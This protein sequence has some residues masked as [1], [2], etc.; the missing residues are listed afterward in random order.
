MVQLYTVTLFHLAPTYT[1]S[2]TC[3]LTHTHTHTHTHTRHTLPL[4]NS[5]HR[6]TLAAGD[7]IGTPLRTLASSL[8]DAAATTA[9]IFFGEVL[10]LDGFLAS[11]PPPLTTGLASPADGFGF[12]ATGGGFLA[13]SELDLGL[14]G[15]STSSHSPLSP[16]SLP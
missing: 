9:G 11:P 1:H 16:L 10:G 8:T 12:E 2:S 3:S 13:T 5:P 4:H 7:F 6:H 14:S 15:G